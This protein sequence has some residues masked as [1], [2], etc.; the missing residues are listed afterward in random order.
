MEHP[1]DIGDRSTIAI[2]LA[3]GGLESGQ[4]D[5][6]I[7]RLKTVVRNQPANI[8]AVLLLAQVYQQTGNKADAIAAFEAARKLADNPDM[9]KEIDRLIK[10]LQ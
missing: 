3:L 2:M 7:E 5:K 10:S 6:A 9:I 8:E 1:K 4:F